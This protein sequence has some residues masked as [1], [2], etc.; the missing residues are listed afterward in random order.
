MSL[1]TSAPTAK[2]LPPPAPGG[3]SAPDLVR[4]LRRRLLTAFFLSGA[5]ALAYQVAWQRLLTVHY[6]V[7]SV[8]I[9]LV[10]SVYMFGLGIGALVGGHLGETARHRIRLY[11]VLELLIGLFG[12]LSPHLLDRLGVAT[13]GSDYRLAGL[14]AFAFLSVPTLLMGATLPLLARI[15]DALAPGFLRTVSALYFVNTLGAALGAV[16]ASYLSI[17]FLGL[18]TTVYLAAAVNLLLAAMIGQAHR[19]S[20]RLPAGA[21]S[22]EPAETA[23]SPAGRRR[24]AGLLSAVFVTGFLAIGYEMVWFRVVGVLIKDSPY[25]FSTML[26][27]LLF[28]IALGSRFLPAVERRLGGLARRD[29]FF[30][31][32]A[33]LG[34]YT[35]AFFAILV[36][37]VARSASVRSLLELSFRQPIHPV[38]RV[39]ASGAELFVLLD[40]VLW[41]AVFFFVPAFLMGLSFPL[42]A[43]LAADVRDA[44]VSGAARKLGLLYCVNVLGNVSG[45]LAVPFLL[46]PAVKTES[47]LLAFGVVGLAL[48]VLVR[49]W[50]GRPLPLAARAAAVGMLLVLGVT[51]FPKN[52]DLYRAVHFS[53]H[54]HAVLEEGREAVVAVFWEGERC[55]AYINGSAHGGRPGYSFYFESIEALSFAPVPRRILVVG[56]GTGSVMESALKLPG[57]KRITLVELNATLLRALRR[58]PLFERMLSDPSVEVVIE[59]GRRYL[60]RTPERFDAIL[61][62]PL[63]TRTAYSNNLY[64]REFFALARSRLTPGGVLMVW[65]DEA[66]VMPHTLSAVFDHVLHYGFFL[67][68]SDQ[69]LRFDAARHE[70]LLAAFPEDVRRGILAFRHLA[71]RDRP[72]LLAEVE[73]APVNR[74]WKPV[75]EYY[76]G[77]E[78]RSRLRRALAAP[79]ASAP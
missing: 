69:P 33:V 76:V 5:A 10:V 61:M 44:G 49:E 40:I 32:Q 18:D 58:L 56:Y 23:P 30:A 48:G 15:Y 63:R 7:G 2:P 38:L 28:G 35:L 73:G 79:R 41:P 8:S 3:Q 37:V 55:L 75:T 54:R 57:E 29:L 24:L 70:G 25:A 77:L 60:L 39:P 4:A 45:G 62:D 17:S 20:R 71:P 34:L 51:A 53:P 1:A 47:T 74:D 26:G 16:G 31:I 78:A 11:C 64:S 19:L 14:G 66:R 46:L 21:V 43:S 52:G 22:P 12:L 42:V 59:D 27:V 9:A 50:S 72:A 13:A 36:G 67:I 68:G 6:G 65:T